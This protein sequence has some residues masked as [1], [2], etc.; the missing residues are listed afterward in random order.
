MGGGV[1]REC[2]GADYDDDSPGYFSVAHASS[3]ARCQETSSR[4]IHAK[5]VPGLHGGKS[6]PPRAAEAF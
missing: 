3:L 5:G 1:D 2:R 4:K 6:P